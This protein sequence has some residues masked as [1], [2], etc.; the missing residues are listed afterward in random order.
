MGF[1]TGDFTIEVWL[2]WHT[3]FV[4]AHSS[5]VLTTNEASGA[6]AVEL[7]NGPGT[8]VCGA[9]PLAPTGAE[10]LVT[11]IL[12]DGTF[13]HVACVRAAGV[14][15]LY[16]DGVPRVQAPNTSAILAPVGGT[17]AIGQPSGLPAAG[18]PPI[19]LGPARISRVARY[20]GA[21]TPRAFWGVDG[22]TVAQWLTSRGFDGTTIHDEA[23]G[24]HDGAASTGVIATTETPC[25]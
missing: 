7:M 19:N 15:S 6:N 22:D 21:F 14:L 2:A 23:G 16:V 17:G 18:A 5:Y 8:I 12:E 25:P 20:N 3:T 13:H 10:A 4:R 9:N 24:N 11:P 1:G